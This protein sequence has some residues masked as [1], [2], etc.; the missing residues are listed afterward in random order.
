MSCRGE[1]RRTH[2]DLPLNPEQNFGMATARTR[3]VPPPTTE[4]INMRSLA[5]IRPAQ[6]RP[7]MSERK[8]PLGEVGSDDAALGSLADRPLCD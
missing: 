2:T 7:T 1:F 3:T 6:I 5:P 8:F 4:R